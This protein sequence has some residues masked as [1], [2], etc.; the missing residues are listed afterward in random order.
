MG[1]PAMVDGATATVGMGGTEVLMM[2]VKSQR[3]FESKMDGLHVLVSDDC[4]LSDLKS[5]PDVSFRS[6]EI[7]QITTT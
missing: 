6:C 3:D 7:I 2:K 1:H 5:Y 4:N